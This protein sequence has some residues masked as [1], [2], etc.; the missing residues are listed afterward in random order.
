M[1]RRTFPSISAALVLLALNVSQALAAGEAGSADAGKPETGQLGELRVAALQPLVRKPERA[2][3]RVLS[4]ADAETYRR[5]F[6]I[7][8]G[9]QWKAADKL[10]ATLDNDRLLGHVMAQRY[11][12]PTKYRSRYKE[13]KAWMD[14]YADHPEAKRIYKLALKRRPK[15]WRRPKAPARVFAPGQRVKVSAR[16]PITVPSKKGLNRKQRYRAAS[17]KRQMRGRLRQGWTKSAKRMLETK[18]V[19][20]LFSRAEY[21]E[22]SA[23]LGFAY[24][25]DGRDEWAVKWAGKAAGRSGK[26]LP[27]AHWTT[28][29]AL[30]RLGRYADAAGHFE[31]IAANGKTSPWFISAGAFWAARAHLKSRRPEKVNPLLK[32]AADHPRTFYGLLAHRI[33]GLPSPFRWETPTM[34]EAAMTA[35][36]NVGAGRRAMALIQ[37]GQFHRAERELRN[38]AIG[39][40]TDLARGILLLASQARMPALSVRLDRMLFPNGGG[41]D[42]AA[43]PLPGW[44]PE[45]GFSIDRAL[46]Y[47]VVRQ[48][49]A[50]KANAKS[51]AG[52]RGLMQ[53]MPGTANFMAGKRRFRG[54]GRKALFD[55]GIN[56]K[57]GQRYLTF[58]IGDGKIAGDLFKLTAAWNG[59]PGNLNKWRR[60][61]D[62]LDDALFFIE[63]L[64]SRETRIFIERVLTNF[65]IY[66]DRLAQPAPSLDAVAAG[67]APVYQALDHN[68]QMVAEHGKN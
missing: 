4:D 27:E 48:E 26:F 68:P 1:N 59:G 46:V 33:L 43:Y 23:R 37:I 34:E 25:I 28:A 16:Q 60:K 31:S 18:E 39:A 12:H 66:R 64:P 5:I 20:R 17:L 15:N 49:S 62:S 52:A 51:W 45:G 35:L 55:P 3:P 24:F 41:Y 8:E 36:N 10:I 67:E 50:F 54:R 57:L 61:V 42:G 65:W 14:R 22:Y 2:L 44:E 53:L 38:I 9:G 21:D 6:Q 58:L 7:Q 63:T 13:L 30:W 40:D 11:L 32:V 56:L 19:K 47:A 29:L